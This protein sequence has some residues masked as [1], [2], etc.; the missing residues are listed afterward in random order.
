M[1]QTSASEYFQNQEMHS[2]L[3]E[4]AVSD[5]RNLQSPRSRGNLY[6]SVE[7]KN[8]NDVQQKIKMK[9]L[10]NQYMRKSSRSCKKRSSRPAAQGALNA[11][12]EEQLILE[13]MREA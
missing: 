8:D 2:R 3:S 1:N 10:G 9:E 12:E 4:E 13:R 6:Q 7:E 5:S 11:K